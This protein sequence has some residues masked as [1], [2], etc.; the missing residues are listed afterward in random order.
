M[1]LEWGRKRL[2]ELEAR[3]AAATGPA[4][5]EW[6]ERNRKYNFWRG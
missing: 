6:R 4:A 3:A 5:Q 1:E 2:K